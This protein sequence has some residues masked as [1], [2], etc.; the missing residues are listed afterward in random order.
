MWNADNG[1][2]TLVWASTLWSLSGLFRLFFP[3]FFKI[4]NKVNF[5]GAR[6]AAEKANQ[7]AISSDGSVLYH[8]NGFDILALEAQ[9]GRKLGLLR[10]HM[11]KVNCCVFHPFSQVP[12][13]ATLLAHL[14]IRSL[15]PPPQELYSGGSDRQLLYWVPSMNEDKESGE[16]RLNRGKMVYT[17]ERHPHH[18]L[19]N[20]TFNLIRPLMEMLGVK[21]RKENDHLGG[22][23]L[24]IEMAKKD[25][26]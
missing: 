13:P 22:T 4:S 5:G 6:N 10:G 12:G 2:N 8:P 23:K 25:S 26:F 19:S 16:R 11:D 15:P 21:A 17:P 3:L 7:M 24:N 20:D 14:G 18:I 9:T 1:K